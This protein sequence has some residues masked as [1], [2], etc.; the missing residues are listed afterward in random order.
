MSSVKNDCFIS[1]FLI[2]MPF[3]LSYFIR[4]NSRKLDISVDTQITVSKK[5]S[6]LFI[7][8]FH[9]IMWYPSRTST[10]TKFILFNPDY[11]PIFWRGEGQQCH[12]LLFAPT[13]SSRA[14]WGSPLPLTPQ[15]SC[16]GSVVSLLSA[17][18]SSLLLISAFSCPSMT[19]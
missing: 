5:W 13:Q 12:L 9:F 2:L 4:Y 1:S 8:Y 3:F 6:L 14:L 16:T 19:S 7:Q 11:F 17:F 18:I 10:S 15:V